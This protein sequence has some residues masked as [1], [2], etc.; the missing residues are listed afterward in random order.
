MLDA[1]MKLR[2]IACVLEVAAR[3]GFGR[4]AEALHLT[5]RVAAAGAATRTVLALVGALRFPA[6]ADQNGN[7]T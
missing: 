2:H 7:P 6:A 4:A 3:A 5:Q 1:R